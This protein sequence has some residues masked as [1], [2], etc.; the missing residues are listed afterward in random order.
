MPLLVFFWILFVLTLFKDRIYK[1]FV[2]V[3]PF[4]KVGDFEIDEGLDNYFKTLDEHDKKWSEKEEENCREV[5]GIPLLLDETLEK[6]K[7]R[8][9]GDKTMQGVHTYDILANYLYLDDFQYFSA[10]RE[11]RA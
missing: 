3:A 7:N 8:Q 4:A 5:I 11:D 9:V 10:D 2:T 1:L 6:I